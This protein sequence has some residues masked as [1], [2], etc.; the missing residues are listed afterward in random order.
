MWNFYYLPFMLDDLKLSGD[1]CGLD[2]G[3]KKV[4]GVAIAR[5]F[6]GLLNGVSFTGVVPNLSNKF[7]LDALLFSISLMCKL[8]LPM[9]YYEEN[10]MYL[11]GFAK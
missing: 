3:M 5:L 1:I 7:I 8:I 4:G 9:K 6:F 10:V 2:L 11:Q